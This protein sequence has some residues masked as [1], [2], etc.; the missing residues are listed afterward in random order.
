MA[1]AKTGSNHK[2]GY[3]NAE[4]KLS[5]T[6]QLIGYGN[7]EMDLELSLMHNILYRTASFLVSVFVTGLLLGAGV[8]AAQQAPVVSVTGG[9][10]RGEALKDGGAVFRGIP[11]AQPPL[12]DLRWREP[13]PVK[14]WTGV[15]EATTFGG[16]CAQNPMW[17]H[18]KVVN[19]DCL[20]LNV[21]TATWPPAALKPVMVWIHGG[22]NVAGSGNENGE[23][24]VRHGI[25][26]VSFNYRLGI[27]G[28]LAHPELSAEA[29][30]HASGNY[31]LM[32][33]IAALKW[34]QEN[35]KKFGGDP[36]NV[37]IFGES[38]GAMDVNLLMASPLAKGLFHRVIAESG[39][40]LLS[41][42]AM[43][44][45]EAE[46]RG[47]QFAEL[48]GAGS[49]GGALKTLRA[50]SV[51]QLLA[52]FG[53]F[54]G[55]SGVPPSLMVAVDG[56][57]LTKSPAEI[58]ASGKQIPAALIIG[59]NARE[60]GGPADA[61]EVKKQIEK[62]YGRLAAQALPLY[63]ISTAADGKV[64]QT[65]PDPLY[66]KAGDQLSTD[67]T[68]RCPAMVVAD[69][70]SKA[71]IPT[72]QYQFSRG[73]PGHPEIGAVHA[74]E[75]AYVF[76]NLDEQR[77]MRPNYE[78]ADYALSKAMQEYWTNFAKTGSPDGSGVPAWPRYQA[79]SRKYLEFTDNGPVAG[80]ELRQK[81][82]EIF[83]ETLRKH[84]E[85]VPGAQ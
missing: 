14:P 83:A 18:P 33:Q 58:F 55:P 79:D 70:N 24:L 3:V 66:G 54:A 63:G 26:L 67:A 5:S 76:G 46:Q 9:S 57:V 44:H 22:G 39:S 17:G 61:A 59:V 40:I 4:L 52:A 38:A 65:A 27:F 80:A 13:K 12:A 82:C 15:R 81:Q 16:E 60:F 1:P 62:D 36:A 49:G 31:G 47:V 85:V 10:V 45:N 30:E 64:S 2:R 77:K 73:I 35:I 72:Y 20:Y 75:V 74:S 37:T 69:W 56:Q 53:K 7:C 71:G 48:A 8:C 28:F 51:E 32:D 84:P 11:F 25:V 42:G 78:A 41:G 68:F 34:V 50:A 21:W 19:E 6:K 29:S 23:S 43:P